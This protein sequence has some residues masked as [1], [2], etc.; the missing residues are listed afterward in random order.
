MSYHSAALAT[1]ENLLGTMDH[2][3]A[4]AQD[5]NVGAKAM[6]AKLAEDMF[7]LETQFR[8]CQNQVILALQRV[9][10]MDIAMEE[11]PYKTL[12]AAREGLARTCAHVAAA[13]ERE[14]ATADTPVDMTL[15][16]GM[17]FVMASHE[18]IRDWT[19][20]NA[21]FHASIAYALLRRDGL[22]L[23]KRDFLP[24]MMRYSRP[25]EG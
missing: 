23:G 15:P 25:A 24:Y 14:A 13:K 10:G 7:P 5:G 12:A 17:R 21:Y 4:R 16:N 8:I 1:F 11:A 3:A 2:L 18:Y 6:Q 20:P 22:D 9:W 19:L